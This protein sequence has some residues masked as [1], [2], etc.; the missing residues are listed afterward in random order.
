MNTQTDTKTES[1]SGKNNGAPASIV[2]FEIPADNVERAK[3]FYG[4]LFGWKIERFPGAKA[5]LAHR[6]RRRRCDARRGNDGEAVSRTQL[7]KLRWR[8]LGRGSGGQGRK[9]WRQN[10]HGKDGR[11]GDGLLRCLSGHG[12]QYLCAVGAERKGEIVVLKRNR[13]FVV[14]S[15][16]ERK[17]EKNMNTETTT[18]EYMLLFRGPHWDRGLTHGR[19][20]TGHGQSHGVV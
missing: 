7:H 1:R 19:T 11:A 14:T 12:E 16:T 9:T 4:K 17:P 2:W 5:V 15:K 6:Y 13:S 10:L 20:A 8:A 18:G 3:T